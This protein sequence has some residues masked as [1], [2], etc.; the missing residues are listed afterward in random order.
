MEN[1]LV[2]VCLK[3][4]FIIDDKKRLKNIGQNLF[5]TI[6]EKYNIASLSFSSV[7]RKKMISVTMRKNSTIQ[8]WSPRWRHFLTRLQV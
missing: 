7:G 1:E 2:V 5:C 3:E 8:R 4:W 6:H